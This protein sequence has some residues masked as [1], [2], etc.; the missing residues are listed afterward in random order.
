MTSQGYVLAKSGP[1]TI[2]QPVGVL[3]SGVLAPS[4]SASL[5]VRASGLDTRASWRSSLPVGLFSHL[6]SAVRQDFFRAPH[7]PEAWQRRRWPGDGAP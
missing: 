1:T 5:R 3:G 7:E 6:T 4:R 2:L